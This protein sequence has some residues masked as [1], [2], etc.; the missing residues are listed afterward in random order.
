MP[1][2]RK[3]PS[4]L[5]PAFFVKEM[6]KFFLDVL[7]AIG[8]SPF[9]RAL[10]AVVVLLFLILVF[11]TFFGQLSPD[12]LF[13]L[14]LVV[15]A[16]VVVTFL[17][18]VFMTKGSLFTPSP[19]ADDTAAAPAKTEGALADQARKCLALLTEIDLANT[20]LINR[21][22]SG[23]APWARLMG[24]TYNNVCRTCHERGRAGGA[25]DEYFDALCAEPD[26]KTVCSRKWLLGEALQDYRQSLDANPASP[27]QHR[28]LELLIRRSVVQADCT[29]S[30]LAAGLA[31]ALAG[32][33]RVLRRKRS[34][35][36]GTQA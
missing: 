14:A 29:P 32:T 30:E 6:F 9:L 20:R 17:V 28:D 7:H 36:T 11:V 15:T 19:G 13:Y 27:A 10:W 35:K 1:P 21:A 3:S 22:Q 31:G 4:G 34:D 25:K 23:A 33:K 18:S 24:E 2:T 26:I 8:G 16:A 12:Q 5:S